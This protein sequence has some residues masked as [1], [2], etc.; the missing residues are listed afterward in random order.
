VSAHNLKDVLDAHS[1]RHDNNQVENRPSRLSL[2][3]PPLTGYH[4][5][6]IGSVLVFGI[7]KVVLSDYEGLVVV[8][9]AELILVMIS[10][11][12]YAFH[13]C[14]WTFVG[15]TASLRL[16]DAKMLEKRPDVCPGFYKV[17]LGPPIWRFVYRS[18]GEYRRAAL[19]GGC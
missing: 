16:Y 12:V 7:W 14:E 1:P 9:R 3:A 5:L 13:S 18:E 10:G 15:L 8:T 17:N 11:L 4:L 2:L 19:V 6:N